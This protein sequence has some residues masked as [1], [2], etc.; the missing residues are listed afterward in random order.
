[1]EVSLLP[2]LMGAAIVCVLLV[3]IFGGFRVL[4]RHLM[5]I[6]PLL[7]LGFSILAYALWSQRTILTRLIVISMLAMML[8]SA[9]AQRITPRHAKDDYRGAALAARETISNGAT[10]WW[11]AD[12]IAANYYHVFPQ[13]LLEGSSAM[14]NAHFSVFMANNRHRQYLAHLPKPALVVL[15]KPDVY[16]ADGQLRGFLADEN[17]EALRSLASFTLY[18]LSE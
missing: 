11:A 15:S 18:S 5:P 14:S 12:P 6:M 7:L 4:G 1:M 2:A 16:D 8:S 10:V 3:G 9:L 13:L 17:Y